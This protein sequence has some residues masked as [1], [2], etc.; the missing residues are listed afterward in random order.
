MHV[1]VCAQ[2]MHHMNVRYSVTR[3]HLHTCVNARAFSEGR[4]RASQVSSRGHVRGLGEEGSAPPN[5]RAQR[6]APGYA[7]L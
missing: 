5:A 4:Q 6:S 1:C 7:Q 2:S 3:A